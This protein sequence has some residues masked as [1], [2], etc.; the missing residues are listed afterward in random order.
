MTVLRVR[1]VFRFC[2]RQIR[3]IFFRSVNVKLTDDL[4]RILSAPTP[5]YTESAPAWMA[6][7]SDSHEPTGAVISIFCILQRYELSGKRGNM[8]TGGRADGRTGGLNTEPVF[9]QFFSGCCYNRFGME[10][11]AADGK[12]LMSQGHDG[13]IMGDCKRFQASGKFGGIDSP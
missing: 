5:K 6:A 2:F 8:Q 3:V 1:Y 9:D 10:L 13:S 4:A 7:V 12:G 11:N